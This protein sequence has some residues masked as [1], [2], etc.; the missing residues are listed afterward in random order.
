MNV[1]DY[2]EM[3]ANLEY[4]GIISDVTYGWNANDIMRLKAKAKDQNRKRCLTVRLWVVISIS[5][6][7]LFTW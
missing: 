1:K 4:V 2:A 5:I 3:A 6:D 7:L